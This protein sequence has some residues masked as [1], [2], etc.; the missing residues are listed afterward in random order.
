MFAFTITGRSLLVVSG[1]MVLLVA[2]MIA[3]SLWNFGAFDSTDVGLVSF[4][5]NDWKQATPI[6]NRRTVRSQMVDDL[7]SRHLLDGLSRAQV[8]AL[9]GPAIEYSQLSGGGQHK[10]DVVYELGL[11]RLGDWSFDTEFLAI[12]FDRNGLVQVYQTIRQ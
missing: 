8:E 3:L 5:S 6:G 11:E 9:L 4:D 10:W 2:G 7:L 12:R 1:G